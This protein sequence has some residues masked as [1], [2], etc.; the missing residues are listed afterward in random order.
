[1]TSP[2]MPL[3]TDSAMRAAAYACT[4]TGQSMLCLLPPLRHLLC[5]EQR[6]HELPGYAKMQCRHL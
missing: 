2:A 3:S 1:M 5:E 6:T 4:H